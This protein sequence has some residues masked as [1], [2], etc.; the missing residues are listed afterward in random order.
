MASV[1]L[2]GG[3]NPWPLNEPDSLSYHLQQ[4]W[5]TLSCP[6]RTES[7]LGAWPLAERREDIG[8]QASEEGGGPH[9]LSKSLKLINLQSCSSA[10]G[11]LSTAGICFHS[12]SECP[13]QVQANIQSNCL[14]HRSSGIPTEGDSLIETESRMVVIWGFR[15]GN[16]E[17]FNRHKVSVMLDE[18]VAQVCCITWH[19]HLTT[20]Y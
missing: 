17:L 18:C 4:G 12:S 8:L 7:S 20:L 16:G 11:W 13:V 6:E 2:P 3:L 9:L 19:L 5:T 1:T 10:P 15:E 14:L